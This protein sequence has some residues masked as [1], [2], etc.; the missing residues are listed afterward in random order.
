LLLLVAVALFLVWRC[1][2]SALRRWLRMPDYL[3]L[4]LQLLGPHWISLTLLLLLH[5]SLPLLLHLLLP[6]LFDLALLFHL[7]LLLASSLLFLE[8]PTS[9][10]LLPPLHLQPLL[11][12][13]F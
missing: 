8:I 1:C 4:L 10:F 7:H 6:H 13:H 9:G 11:L 5:L 12:T 3:L 2:R